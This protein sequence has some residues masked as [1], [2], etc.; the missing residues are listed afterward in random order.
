MLRWLW[1]S[2]VVIAADQASKIA[3]ERLLSLHEQ[4]A[5]IP[6][7]F[8]FTLA[9]NEGAAFSFLSNAGGWQR[10]FFT[11]LAIGVSAILIVWLKR[12]KPGDWQPALALALIIGGA[13][14]NLIDRM[15]YGHV[16]DFIQWYYRDWYW[17]SFNIADSA[18]SVGAA[19]LILTA[20]FG[21]DEAASPSE[22]S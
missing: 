4:V 7:F 2:A 8:N 10:W 18:I 19:I 14:G 13:L 5:V 6:G 1:L 20:L 3:A 21:H 9:Y 17:P 11:A 16:I 12:L 15:A 22:S